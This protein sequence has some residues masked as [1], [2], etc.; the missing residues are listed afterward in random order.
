MV[1]SV[2]YAF[3][4]GFVASE[5]TAEG[6]LVDTETEHVDFS[7]VLQAVPRL[8][9]GPWWNRGWTLVEPKTENVDFPL[10]LKAFSAA[11]KTEKQRRNNGETTARQPRDTPRR[12]SL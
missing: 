8:F 3:S 12:G 2:D 5:T 10:V 7:L 1:S 11:C 9:G 4:S 6:S